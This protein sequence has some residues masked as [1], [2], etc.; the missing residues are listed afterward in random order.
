MSAD[1]ELAEFIDRTLTAYMNSAAF[2][3]ALHA[4]EPHRTGRPQTGICPPWHDHST[5]G[6]CYANHG[7]RCDQCRAA[8]SA[9]Q[10]RA[11]M[12][13]AKRA[14]DTRNTTTTKETA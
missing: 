12:N 4:E 3:A 6:T 1:I 9:R 10:K 7:C 8:S 11:R 2:R 14:W 13:R 5:T